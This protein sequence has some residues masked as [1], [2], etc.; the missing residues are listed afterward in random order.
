[1]FERIQ[2]AQAKAEAPYVK[3]FVLKLAPCCDAVLSRACLLC[4]LRLQDCGVEREPG[5]GKNHGG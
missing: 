5:N 1:M 3:R 4:R 2:R